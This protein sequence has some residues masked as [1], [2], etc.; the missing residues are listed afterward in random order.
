MNIVC[1]WFNNWCGEYG[2]IYVKRLHQA[3]KYNSSV[4]FKFYCFTDN[5]SALECETILFEP[6]L[7]RNLNK[8]QCFD[9]KFGLKGDIV[10]F[11]LDTMILGNID[12]FLH[13]GNLFVTQQN[14]R[15]RKEAGGGIIGAKDWYGRMHFN[16]IVNNKGEVEEETSGAERLYIRKYI[17][18]VPFWNVSRVYS[19]KVHGVPEEARVIN[20]HGKPRPHQTEVGREY[21]NV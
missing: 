19:Y 7:L 21:L 5:P 16:Y 13:F 6:Y 8:F 20:F 2:P 15:G 10:S 3:L 12:P 1:F 18:Q 11:D 9:S 14:M 4:N 17:P